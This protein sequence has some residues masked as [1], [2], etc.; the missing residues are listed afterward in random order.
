MITKVKSMAKTKKRPTKVYKQLSVKE[1]KKP[2]KSKLLSRLAQL[3]KEPTYVSDETDAL[4]AATVEKHS[5]LVNDML[6][7][8]D[9]YVNDIRCDNG[10][11]KV[12][13][14]LGVGHDLVEDNIHLYV[15]FD[16]CYVLD[17]TLVKQ[18]KVL[19]LDAF[20]GNP[21]SQT[22]VELIELGFDKHPKVKALLKRINDMKKRWAKLSEDERTI[23]AVEI[24]N[25]TP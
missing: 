25:N 5:A 15:G 21:D 7:L 19:G 6:V 4:I 3:T 2:K 17:K 1:T 24:E 20:L 9:A 18:L 12:E 22:E 16:G 10:R 8:F 11:I 14:S 23:L 13:M